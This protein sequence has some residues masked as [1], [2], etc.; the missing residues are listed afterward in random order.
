M[1]RFSFCVEP[2]AVRRFARAL[3]DDDPDYAQGRAVPPT[4]V[5]SAD[6]DDP[7][8][9]RR[10]RSGEKWYGSAREARNGPMPGA[11]DSASGFH[12]EQEFEYHRP[13][14]VGERLEVTVREGRHWHKQ[15]RRGG[16]LR[17]SE[18]ISEFRDAQGELV[19]SARFVG[20]GTEREVR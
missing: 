9:D 10:P 3:G 13:L 2:G 18:T 16:R 8:Y 4:F 7:D 15:G 19:V 12:A 20:V 17:F 5:Q 1:R 11:G 14:R 6:H